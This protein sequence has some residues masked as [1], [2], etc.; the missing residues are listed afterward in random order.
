M[1]QTGSGLEGFSGF[2]LQAIL[3]CWDCGNHQY[4]VNQLIIT[5]EYLL[6]SISIFKWSVY[7][8]D[9]VDC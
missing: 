1:G 8:T 6:V 3:N 4:Q 9:L 2:D 7:Q 5:M